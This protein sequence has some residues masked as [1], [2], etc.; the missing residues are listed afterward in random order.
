MASAP[1]KLCCQRCGV[2]M[3]PHARKCRE[4]RDSVELARVDPA[5]GGVL[6]Q[7]HTCPRCG[8]T[9]ARVGSDAAAGAERGRHERGD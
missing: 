4:P 5:L 8:E 6:V 9:A 3:N 1:L 7:L 2:E